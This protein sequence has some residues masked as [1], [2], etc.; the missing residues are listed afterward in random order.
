M[1]I[2]EFIKQ[3]SLRKWSKNPD[4]YDSIELCP[5][6]EYQTVDDFIR[7]IKEWQSYGHHISGTT[8]IG[9]LDDHS[10]VLDS[11][12][13]VKGISGLRVVHSSVYPAPYLHAHHPSRGIYM[14]AEVAS[15]FIKEEHIN[16]IDCDCQCCDKSQV[17]LHHAKAAVLC[18]M[19]FRLRDNMVCHLNLKGYK[20][21]YDE[22]IAAGASLGYNGLSTYQ[23]WDEY[24]DSHITLAYKLHDISEIIIV[25]HEKCD[26]YKV[27]YGN[28]TDLSP[29]D[30]KKYHL[31]N[32]II[33]TEKLWEKYNPDTGTV[34]KIPDLKIVAYL[35]S[36]DACLFTE[37]Y[38]KSEHLIN[39][40]I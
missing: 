30:E 15:D 18:C 36:I 16:D 28:G 1:K 3:S 20:N 2:R 31:E 10:A 19:D 7:Y 12:L 40:N 32:A 38:S 25:E 11:R 39:L 6:K 29:E 14:I 33:C 22:V 23:K 35:I 27:Q 26:A 13:R 17:E 8:K 5:G 21:D 37:I 34:L 24:I 9:K 4:D